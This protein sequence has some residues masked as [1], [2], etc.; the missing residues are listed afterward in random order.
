MSNEVHN[1]KSTFTLKNIGKFIKQSFSVTLK[2]FGGKLLASAIMG[3]ICFGIL[4]ILGVERAVP[5]AITAGVLNLVPVIGGL[6]AAIICGIIAV[7]QGFVF[8]LYAV[9]TIILVQ[10]LDQWILTPLIVGKTVSLPPLIICV[11]L[12]LGG[13]AWGPVGVV[14]A[15]PVAGVVK[16]FYSIFVK[17]EPTGL[18]KKAD[19]V[20]KEDK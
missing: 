6:V 16:L 15:V 19:V 8:I 10:Q 11:A 13:W 12:I 17:D 4:K 3:I 1:K 20:I 18:D 9:L 7:F 5:M 2:Y 14:I